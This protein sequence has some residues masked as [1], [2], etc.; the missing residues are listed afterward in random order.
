M[1]ILVSGFNGA[2]KALHPRLLPESGVGAES[3]NQK[4]GR[5]DLR[6]WRQPLNVA[7]VPSGRV[8]FY[9][10]NRD[11]ASDTQYWLS[12]AT[13]VHAARGPLGS[14]TSER[15]Y[16]TGDG[17]PKVTDN[18]TGLVSPPYPSAARLLGVPHP[19]DP[20]SLAVGA[21][22]T[23]DDR[24]QFYV[25]TFITDR[26]EESKPGTPVSIEVPPGST[27]DITNLE[28][29]PAGNYGITLRR[30]Y[31]LIAGE[32]GA[33]YFRIIEQDA[34]LTN[35]T[36]AALPAS[37]IRLKTNGPDGEEGRAWDMPPADGKH[38]TPLWG[39]M[40]AMISGRAVRICEAYQPHAWPIAYEVAPSDVTARALAVW[41]KYLLVL[42][43]GKPYVITGSIPSGMGDE[44]INFDQS[45]VSERS[46]AVVADGVCWA[47]PDGIAYWGARGPRLLTA[48]LMTRDDWQALKPET[49]VGVQYEGAYLLFFEPTPGTRRGLAIDPSN[50]QG[51]YFLD[52]GYVAGHFDKANDSLY[53]LDGVNVRKW[54]A[55]AAFMT[56]TFK[57]KQHRLPRPVNLGWL[58]VTADV[59]P[60][61]VTVTAKWVDSGG[62]ERTVTQP[63]SVTSSAPT[64]LKS[65][66]MATDWQVEVSTAGAVQGVALA[67]TVAELAQT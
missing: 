8:S 31:R 45:C 55:G 35:A 9:R 67:E 11:V 26:G 51:I 47:A 20:M 33:E 14:D 49:M 1:R 21:A 40:M 58:E 7:T 27:I 23:G 29:A 17:V 15:T 43:N 63:L 53:V 3:R 50:P 44:T 37:A 52:D 16:Y 22:G 4:P 30:I 10:M 56:A 25:D 41:D 18:L 42:T 64:T 48:G 62:I 19:P 12:W 13:L 24:F 46:P 66:F 36:D 60:V 39:G 32:T 59:Y 5:G 54:D 65:G 28:P 61:S 38:L 34:T 57:S 2:N 6:P